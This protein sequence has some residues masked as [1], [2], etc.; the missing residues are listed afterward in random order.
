MCIRDR[1]RSKK[2]KKSWFKEK[3]YEDDFEGLRE[4]AI[5]WGITL[6]ELIHEKN[7]QEENEG[8]QPNEIQVPENEEI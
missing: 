8:E 7:Q 3:N 4:E 2:E 1:K 5:E 6:E